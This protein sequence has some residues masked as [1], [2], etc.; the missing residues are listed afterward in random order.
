VGG[1]PIHPWLRGRLIKEVGAT[2]F[3]KG[4]LVPPYG[5][6]VD[7]GSGATLPM[8]GGFW[9]FKSSWLVGRRLSHCEVVH[10][11]KR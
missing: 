4:C 6:G 2:S 3:V 11:K 1:M 8:G 9:P 10:Y 5:K 7:K